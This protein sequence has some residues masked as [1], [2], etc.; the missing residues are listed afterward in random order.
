MSTK[1]M[2][3]FEV[4]TASAGTTDVQLTGTASY[5]TGVVRGAWSAYS[6]RVNP[7]TT[8][9]GFGSLFGRSVSGTSGNGNMDAATMFLR[10]YIYVVTLPASGEEEFLQVADS[11]PA[12]KFYL[13]L[14]SAGA[15]KAYDATPTLIAAGTAVLV[16]G[17]WYR[18]ELKLG[19][20]ASAAVEWKVTS[21]G[22]PD[23]TAAVDVSTT[24][25]LSSN[26]NNIVRFGKT[27]DRSSQSVEFIYEDA[28]VSNS[29]YPGPGKGAMLVADANG[30]YQTATVGAGSGSHY[31][32]VSVVPPDVA[33]TTSYLVTS[34]TAGQ[35]ETEAMQPSSAKGIAGIIN[36]VAPLVY[37]KRD[38]ASNGS[39]AL[40]LRSGSTDTD[41]TAITTLTVP[42][43]LSIYYD[44]DPATGLAWTT[45]GIDGCEVGVVENSANKTRVSAAFLLVDFNDAGGS[46]VTIARSTGALFGTNETTGSGVTNGQTRAGNEIDVLGDNSSIGEVTLYLSFTAPSSPSGLIRVEIRPSRVSG[47]PCQAP[48]ALTF[49]VAAQE[50]SPVCLGRFKCSR[51]LTAAIT[52]LLASGDLA[53]VA[54][55]YELEK[56]S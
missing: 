13:R 25:T 54:V 11:T 17:T 56:T 53:N 21:A 48:D 44:T 31:Q 41:G 1:A 15:I 35:A 29:A 6:L 34:G 38:G 14:T 3:S 19:T 10:F 42:A 22:S 18:I 40:R 45:S 47:T 52:N 39:I 32:I 36:C 23:G 5:Y 7:T 24:A 33:F 37:E 12:A 2:T 46:T 16:T 26:N 49:S 50:T 43:V 20:G 30:N 8:G 9:T 28:L 51:Y 4:G 55:L 27:A